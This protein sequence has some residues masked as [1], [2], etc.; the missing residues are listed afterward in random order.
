VVVVRAVV[1]AYRSRPTAVWKC[2]FALASSLSL[3]QRAVH[4]YP[5]RYPIL[6]VSL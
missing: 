3:Q 1:A 4:S 2:S 5:L 6:S